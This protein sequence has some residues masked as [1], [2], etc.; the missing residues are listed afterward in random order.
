[1]EDR[2]MD[3]YFLFYFYTNNPFDSEL[4]GNILEGWY[5]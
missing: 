1:M 2:I 4:G 5:N 3:V